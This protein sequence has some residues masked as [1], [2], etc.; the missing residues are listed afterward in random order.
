MY[1]DLNAEEQ[2]K[3]TTTRAEALSAPGLQSVIV[4]RKL[5]EPN[6]IYYCVLG[7]SHALGSWISTN[8]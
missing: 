4:N 1:Q 7:D 3:L 2:D 6:A 5:A 8:K